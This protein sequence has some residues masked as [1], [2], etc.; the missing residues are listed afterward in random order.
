MDR[1]EAPM[2]MPSD[3]S[4]FAEHGVD[5]SNAAAPEDVWN[6]SYIGRMIVF[7]Q[8]MKPCG[9]WSDHKSLRTPFSGLISPQP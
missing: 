8:N 5:S 4:F 3:F 1:V 9:K 6:K 7:K 2:H